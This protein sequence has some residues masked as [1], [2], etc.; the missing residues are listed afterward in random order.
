VDFV[1]ISFV[2]DAN[3]LSN[4]RS[5]IDAQ[6]RRTH[7]GHRIDVVAK[8]EAYDSIPGLPAIIEAGDA[9]MVARSDL[10]A[11]I[12]MEDVPAVQKEVVFRCRQVRGRRVCTHRMHSG[13]ARARSPHACRAQRMR[14]VWGVTRRVGADGQAG[15]SG[16]AAAQQHD[17]RTGADAR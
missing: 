2:R 4:V 16:V 5:Y 14:A 10:G 8:I 11:Q 15:D 17:G 3:I 12:P 7:P 13:R 1:A 6:L 9:I